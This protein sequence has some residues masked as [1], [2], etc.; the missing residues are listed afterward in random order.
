MVNLVK[1][2]PEGWNDRNG[3]TRSQELDAGRL[4]LLL[5][6]DLK[7][8]LRFNLLTLKPELDGIELAE[9]EITYLYVKLGECGWKI[10]KQSAID[11]IIYAARKNYDP[12]EY[13]LAQTRKELNMKRI[14]IYVKIRKLKTNYNKMKCY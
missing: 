1:G 11:S 13:L 14:L 10:G 4:S 5:K 6:E 7:D 2:L 12:A 8:R 3:I 9:T